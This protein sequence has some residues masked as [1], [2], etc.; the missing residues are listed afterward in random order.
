LILEE[1]LLYSS[2]E[3]NLINWKNSKNDPF[4]IYFILSFKISKKEKKENARISILSYGAM[5]V[6]V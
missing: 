4:I 3:R 6:Q 1:K 2:L 5:D